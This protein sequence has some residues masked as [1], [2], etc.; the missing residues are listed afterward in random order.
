M[1]RDAGFDYAGVRFL[2][3]DYARTVTGFPDKTFRP[4]VASPVLSSDRA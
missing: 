3:L 1:I 2:D 4:V